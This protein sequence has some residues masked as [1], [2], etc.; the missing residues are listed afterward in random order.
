[1]TVPIALNGVNVI[2]IVKYHFP[3]NLSGNI[4]IFFVNTIM[5]RNGCRVEC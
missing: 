3:L 1:M 5:P 4:T 2:I